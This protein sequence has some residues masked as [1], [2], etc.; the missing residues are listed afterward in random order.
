MVVHDGAYGTLLARHL[1]GGET[2]DDLCLRAPRL[3][4]D[5]HRSYLESGAR[6]IQT[7][8]FLAFR[9]ADVRRRELQRAAF[10]CARQALE[11]SGSDGGIAAT[12]GPAGEEPRSFWRDMEFAL[13]QDLRIVLCETITGAAVARAAVAAWRDVS[14]GVDDAQLMLGCSVSPSRGVDDS[15]WLWEIAGTAP[16]EVALGL[17]CCEGPLGL[18]PT[19]ERLCELRGASWVMP[20][21]GLPG[22][23]ALEAADWAVAVEELVA[24]LPIGAVGGCC[25]TSPAE[26][27]ALV[28][29]L[30]LQ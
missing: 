18:R 9:R 7:N 28:D 14:R 27:R 21:A 2:V 16:E 4:V 24:G 13:E 20:S 10:D 5:A 12:I 17:N 6:V 29:R 11:E 1:R 25:G 23:G 8:T 15:A 22:Q 30:V 3:V 26:V 19:L